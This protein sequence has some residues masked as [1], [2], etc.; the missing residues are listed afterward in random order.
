MTLNDA[1]KLITGGL[2]WLPERFDSPEARAML[3]AIGLQESRFMHRRQ[4]GGPA[5]GYWQ[6]EHG[7]GVRG[8]LHHPGTGGFARE[9]MTRLDYPVTSEAAYNAL[10]DNDV[11]A[12]VF[13]RLL[14]FTVPSALPESPGDAWQQY[15]WAWRP[16]KPHANTWPGYFERARRFYGLDA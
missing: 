16:G 6:F 15:L 1:D 11:L 14:L 2:L 3:M 12:V 4:I 10:P 7:G 9:V 8:V 5:N 13:A